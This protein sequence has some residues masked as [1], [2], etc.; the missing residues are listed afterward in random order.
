MQRLHELQTYFPYAC[1]IHISTRWRFALLQNS[2][3]S[4]ACLSQNVAK[5]D[6]IWL[7]CKLILAP[8]VSYGILFYCVSNLL[9]AIIYR[10]SCYLAYISILIK[11]YARCIS[12]F[13][14]FTNFLC[15]FR[16]L[17]VTLS[18]RNDWM[19]RHW[20]RRL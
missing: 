19:S 10:R 9:Q 16:V 15:N 2:F 14:Q 7:K 20:Q 18:T 8:V 1:E 11:R 3:A 13:L 12:V 17:W 4:S 6:Q 5:H